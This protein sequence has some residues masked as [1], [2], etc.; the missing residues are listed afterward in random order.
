MRLFL[1]PLTK[2]ENIFVAT[3]GITTDKDNTLVAEIYFQG[4]VICIVLHEDLATLFALNGNVHELHNYAVTTV[5]LN[6]PC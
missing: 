5:D 6:E 4:Q 1:L 2:V 3:G